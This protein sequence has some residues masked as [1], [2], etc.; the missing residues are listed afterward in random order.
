VV[1]GATVVAEAAGART[2]PAPAGGTIADGTYFLTKHEVYAPGTPD[3]STR[4]RTIVFTGDKWE[5]HENDPGKGNIQGSGT[6][7]T[8]GI[9]ITFS[10]GCFGGQLVAGG[11][12][13]RYTSTDT[14]FMT[15]TPDTDGDVFT[16]TRQ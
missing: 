1:N 12:S 14:T 3:T 6:Y 16:S 4:R 15:F 5:T 11:S 9:M 10:V 8:S 13:T 7:T 2:K